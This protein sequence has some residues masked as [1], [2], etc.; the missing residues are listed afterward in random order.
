[1]RIVPIG[2]NE[3]TRRN[4]KWVAD[5]SMLRMESELN[6]P[7][8]A[9]MMTTRRTR[10]FQFLMGSLVRDGKPRCGLQN[11]VGANARG[12]LD[13]VLEPRQFHEPGEWGGDSSATWLK[14]I[15]SR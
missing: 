12:L 10:R 8:S 14:L 11:T 5:S 13:S 6:N 9:D 7:Q 1:M 4:N 2:F 15:L 3:G